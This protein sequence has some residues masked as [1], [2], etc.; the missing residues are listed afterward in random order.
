M[1]SRRGKGVGMAMAT[2]RTKESQQV[3]GAVDGAQLHV[4]VANL[5]ELLGVLPSL[6]SI[7]QVVAERLVEVKAETSCHFG[8]QAEMMVRGSARCPSDLQCA[9]GKAHRRRSWSS[10][11][12]Y[13]FHSSRMVSTLGTRG[14]GTS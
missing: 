12:R 2:R 14:R 3:L 11:W 5:L 1:M 6:E 13:L 10:F 9:V 8:G 4:L 7:Q